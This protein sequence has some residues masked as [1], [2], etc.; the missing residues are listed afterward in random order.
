MTRRISNY[1]QK[2]PII[3][4]YPCLQGEGSRMGKPI[5]TSCTHRCYF[6]SGGWCD[7]WYTSIHPEKGHFC[8]QDIVNLH[9]KMPY[10]REFMVTGGSPTM[11]FALM[12]E[13][14]HYA[15][16]HQIFVTLETEG[17]HDLP[18]DYPFDLI[19]LSPKFS[20][21]VPIKG[22]QTPKGQIVDQK[23]INQHEKYRLNH[24]AIAKML[25]YH[26]DYQL[27]PVVNEDD[28]LLDEIKAFQ[29]T[30]R[31]PNHKTYLMPGG[32]TRQQMIKMY[33][34][35]MAMCLR[36]GY[37]FSGREHIIAY[38]DERGV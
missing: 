21:T 23:M 24:Q 14:A 5:I 16:K 10:I 17:S 8:F 34:I 7:T 13:I 35:V 4:L 25:A 15:Y 26:Q 38:D 30:H 11:H 19:S 20:N 2:L 37:N 29:S 27:K 33:P 31:I 1:Q 22:I 9:Q 18:T 6:G 28:S 32:Q 12:N 36:E 3:E